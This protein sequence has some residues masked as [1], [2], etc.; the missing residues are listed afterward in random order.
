[1]NIWKFNA[2]YHPSCVYC[3]FCHLLSPSVTF[4]H[5]LSP[6]SENPLWSDITYKTLW[7][8]ADEGSELWLMN[9]TS[10]FCVYLQLLP[11]TCEGQRV[12]GITLRLN[13]SYPA[14][15]LRRPELHVE[16]LEKAMNTLPVPDSSLYNWDTDNASYYL[17]VFNKMMI[18]KGVLWCSQK[19]FIAIYSFSLTY[20]INLWWWCWSKWTAVFYSAQVTVLLHSS[21]S[22]NKQKNLF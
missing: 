18:A 7:S 3:S 8:F 14:V 17:N 10:A 12:A 6:F 21:L 13:V 4:C 9:R 15:A 5:L 16:S 20:H 22:S 19:Y 11:S 1:M 2:T